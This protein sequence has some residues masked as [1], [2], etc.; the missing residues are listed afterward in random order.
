MT[1]NDQL[2]QR[3]SDLER[4]HDKTR[5]LLVEAL[6]AAVVVSVGV[7]F[8]PEGWHAA[9]L[10][11]CGAVFIPSLLTSLFLRDRRP[12]PSPRQRVPAPVA[13]WRGLDRGSI[14]NR[15]AAD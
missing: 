11:F 12:Q 5:G 2:E 14:G 1:A 13:P 15:K 10:G 7:Y 4:R 8:G 9:M 3:V 6:S